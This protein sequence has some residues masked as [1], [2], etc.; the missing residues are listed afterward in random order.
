MRSKKLLEKLLKLAPTLST[1]SAHLES[2]SDV[3]DVSG[4]T[5]TAKILPQ[6]F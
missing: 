3:L 6:L 5:A 4:R 2:V 1:Y